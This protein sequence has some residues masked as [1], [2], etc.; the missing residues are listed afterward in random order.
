[1]DRQ[2]VYIYNKN[3][4]LSITS[5]S[6]RLLTYIVVEYS[7]ILITM[8]KEESWNFFQTMNGPF[9]Q[10]MGHIFWV[11]WRIV[12]RRYQESTVHI[13]YY[14]LYDCNNK[15]TLSTTV[16][17]RL[18]HIPF[19]M[20]LPTWKFWYTSIINS[21]R[22]GDVYLHHWNGSALVQ[23][24]AGCLFGTKLLPESMMTYYPMD[25]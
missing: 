25:A 13:Y 11:L 16:I 17:C 4:A 12:T 19:L 9:R 6:Y 22:P 7:T 10:A 20:F 2:M 5:K 23:V 18:F 3:L 21:L 8:W 15:F 14:L 24:M 1:M